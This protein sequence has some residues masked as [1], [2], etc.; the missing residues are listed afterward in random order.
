MTI[1]D[2]TCRPWH[3]PFKAWEVEYTDDFFDWWDG[4]S[5]KEQVDIKAVVDGT[6][7][8]RAGPP[9]ASCW[10]DCDL[11]A[12]KHEGVDY[13]TCRQTLS[14]AVRIRPKAYCDSADWWE[15]GR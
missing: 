5:A 15:Q 4:L 11:P 2:K 7:R 6:S 3:I 1:R 8:K 14:G 13:S 12:C 9:Q 10:S